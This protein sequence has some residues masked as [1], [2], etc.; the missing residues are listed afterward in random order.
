ME[1]SYNKTTISPE[2]WS[3]R[4]MTVAHERGPAARPLPGSAL[5]AE[6]AASEL[7]FYSPEKHLVHV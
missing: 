3:Q 2:S 1:V 7:A 4:T 5:Q 6:R